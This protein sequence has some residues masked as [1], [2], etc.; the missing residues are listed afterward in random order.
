M[1]GLAGRFGLF[2]AALCGFLGVVLGAFGA[3]ALGPFLVAA[4]RTGTWETAVLYHLVHAVAALWAAGRFPVVC[5]LWLAG[6]VVFSGSLYVL[7]LSGLGIWGAVT[8]IGG[9]LFLAGWVGLAVAVW[10]DPAR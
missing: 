10:R 4:G 3:H 5:G 1:S 9:L 2:G 7:C 8:P 6:V